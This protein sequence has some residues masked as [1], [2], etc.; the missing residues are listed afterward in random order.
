MKT[1]MFSM[2]VLLSVLAIASTASATII[3]SGDIVSD[4]ND[5]GTVDIVDGNNSQTLSASLAG[6]EY[7]ATLFSYQVTGT[8]VGTLQPFLAIADGTTYKPIAVGT[9]VTSSGSAAFA[10]HSFGGSDTFTLS[11]DTTVYAG[12]YFSAANCPIGYLAGGVP[13]GLWTAG[14][15]PVPVVGVDLPGAELLGKLPSSSSEAVRL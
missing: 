3:G 8:G 5:G 4:T 14:N 11:A 15:D 2:C 6:Q 1:V 12:F 13:A 9:H 10:D 7:K